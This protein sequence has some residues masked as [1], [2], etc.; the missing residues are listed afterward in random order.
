MYLIIRVPVCFNTRV[1]KSIQIKT[2]AYVLVYTCVFNTRSKLW[3]LGDDGRH[4]AA[5]ICTCRIVC[6]F[7]NKWRKE[8]QQRAITTQDSRS[9][10]TENCTVTKSLS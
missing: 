6:V 7:G 4:V 9:V 5:N 10:L 3:P 2:Q 8:R 1:L